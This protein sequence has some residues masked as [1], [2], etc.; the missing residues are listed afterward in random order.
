ML[1]NFSNNYELL[2]NTM[3]TI[4]NCKTQMKSIF[5]TGVLLERVGGLLRIST[6]RGERH[7][8]RG[9]LEL[10]QYLLLS[11][12]VWGNILN[13]DIIVIVIIVSR[14]FYTKYI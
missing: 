12:R 8:E 4:K 1:C 5:N 7:L 2:H 10:L 9:L 6:S 3:N 11:K 14:P 13:K